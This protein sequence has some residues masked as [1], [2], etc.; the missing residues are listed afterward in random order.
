MISSILL[1]V[2][3]YLV[4]LSDPDLTLVSGIC[5]EIFTFSLDFPVLLSIGFCSMIS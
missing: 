4:D 5:L 2:M 3:G 1:G